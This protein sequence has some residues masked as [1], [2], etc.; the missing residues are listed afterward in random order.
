MI[1]ATGGISH[2]A[3]IPSKNT[4]IS[5]TF[6]VRIWSYFKNMEAIVAEAELLFTDEGTVRRLL[7]V[8]LGAV[9]ELRKVWLVKLFECGITGALAVTGRGDGTLS[10]KDA[11]FI[12]EM[13]EVKHEP[14]GVAI[15]W[16]M[17]T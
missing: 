11:G 2:V 6:N 3:G 14:Q 10:K 5:L 12:L 8:M 1:A 16:K 4:A 15:D 13:G 17:R 9:N 7:F